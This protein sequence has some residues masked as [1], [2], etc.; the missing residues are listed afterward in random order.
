MRLWEINK[1]TDEVWATG[2]RELTGVPGGEAV[3]GL[4][5][6]FWAIKEKAYME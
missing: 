5:N 2:R 4:S 6:K 1:R 3:M